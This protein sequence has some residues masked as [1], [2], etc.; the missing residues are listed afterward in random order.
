L[1]F[2]CPPSLLFFIETPSA[3]LSLPNSFSCSKAL[4]RG[5][6]LSPSFQMALL[7]AH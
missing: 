4:L 6:H 3:A 2:F 1:S 5:S 7:Y